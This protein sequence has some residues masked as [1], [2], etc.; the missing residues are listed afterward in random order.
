MTV[1]VSFLFF[2]HIFTGA[3]ITTKGGDTVHYK[4]L[5]DTILT[6]TSSMYL[7]FALLGCLFSKEIHTTE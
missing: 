1:M 3:E 7:M 2:P 6:C 4:Y 5:T